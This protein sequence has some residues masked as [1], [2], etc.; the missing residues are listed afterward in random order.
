[1]T[2]ETR[3]LANMEDKGFT[4]EYQVERDG[5]RCLT[6]NRFYKADELTV[7]NY[8]RFEG[9][10]NPDDMSIIYAILTPDGRKGV[11]IDAYGLYADTRVEDIIMHA[12]K[13]E[14]KKTPGWADDFS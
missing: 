7:V 6:T 4:D 2:P 5:L 9:P 10:S 12:R 8:Y 13:F 14:Q 3:C 11:L 1:M